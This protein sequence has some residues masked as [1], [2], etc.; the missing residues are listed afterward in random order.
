[1]GWP[2][3]SADYFSAAGYIAPQRAFK[4]GITWPFYVQAGRNNSGNSSKTT[5]GGGANRGAARGGAGS[6][7]QPGRAGR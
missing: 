7:R 6:G 5:A 2:N 1:M 4:I 3:E